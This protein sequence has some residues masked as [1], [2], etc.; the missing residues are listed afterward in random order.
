MFLNHKVYTAFIF[1]VCLSMS[2]YIKFTDMDSI[3]NIRNIEA[4]YHTLLTADALASNPI[5]DHYMLP[6]VTLGKDIDHFVPWGATKPTSTGSYIYTS[7]YSPAFV[8]AHAFF[9]MTNLEL[10]LVN[11]AILNTVLHVA[12]LIVMVL[13]GLEVHNRLSR[14]SESSR[15]SSYAPLK[16]LVSSLVLIFSSESL[17]SYG[18]VYWAQSLLNFTMILAIYLY[19]KLRHDRNI[20]KFSFLLL[21]LINPL[22]EWTGFIFNIGLII[23]SLIFNKNKAL[24]FKILAITFFSGLILVS[25]Y[26]LAIGVVNTIEG[27]TS[28]FF[29]RAIDRASF[30]DLALG[31]FWSYSMFFVPFVWAAGNVMEKLP[32]LDRTLQGLIFICFFPLIEN[33]IMLQHAS[34]F[35]FDRLKFV[36]PV[37]VVFFLYFRYFGLNVIVVTLIVISS[38]MNIKVYGYLER[39][40]LRWASIHERNVMFRDEIASQVDLSCSLLTTDWAVRGYYNRLFDRAIVEGLSL[41]MSENLDNERYCN[42]VHV[43]VHGQPN[44]LVMIY[45]YKIIK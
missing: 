24:A 8:V 22:I 43:N 12:S 19:I 18:V 45:D 14:D 20:V 31:Y 38:I 28:R 17:L 32:S 35:S 4:S 9:V 27:F 26:V 1:F 42:H 40:G 44:D 37:F 29:A 13:L 16:I 3:Y 6:T 41:E 30:F 33:I 25:H 5:S 39:D 23:A 15:Y 7:F 34:Q 11:L 2:V 36:I 10:N 21:V